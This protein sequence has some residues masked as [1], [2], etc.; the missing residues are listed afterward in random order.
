MRTAE[1]RPGLINLIQ[2]ANKAGVQ[3]NRWNRVVLKQLEA[4][5][6]YRWRPCA[7]KFGTFPRELLELRLW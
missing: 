1:K 5:L 2:S 7:A 4:E 3:R 6:R